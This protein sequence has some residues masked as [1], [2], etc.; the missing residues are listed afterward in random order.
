M[1]G[2]Q[3][4]TLHKEKSSRCHF[5]VVPNLLNLLFFL[6]LSFSLSA[7]GSSAAEGGTSDEGGG[8]AVTGGGGADA[9]EGGVSLVVADTVFEGGGWVTLWG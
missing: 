8:G 6:A 9:K 5:L 1:S 2:R 4:S 3:K 7:L